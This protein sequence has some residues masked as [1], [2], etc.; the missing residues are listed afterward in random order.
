MGTASGND[1]VEQLCRTN[2]VERLCG[3]TR[4]N[5]YVERLC[6]TIM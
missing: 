6:R 4:G 1:Y 3:T 5:D 2:R